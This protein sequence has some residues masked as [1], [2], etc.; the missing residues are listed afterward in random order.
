MTESRR[1]F[2]FQ[3]LFYGSH[4]CWWAWYSLAAF[5]PC[6]EGPGDLPPPGCYTRFDF[7]NDF[8]VDL[9]DWS[10]LQNTEFCPIRNWRDE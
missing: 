7:D 6:M 10:V 8:D 9:K 2:F 3:F 1:W 5:P 4:F